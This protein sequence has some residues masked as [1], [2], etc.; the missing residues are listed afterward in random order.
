MGHRTLVSLTLKL[1][2]PHV[3]LVGSQVTKGLVDVVVVAGATAFVAVTRT[4]PPKRFSATA[5][6]ATGMSTA[7]GARSTP[8][9][10]VQ[11]G[12]ALCHRRTG[13]THAAMPTT[14]NTPPTMAST[15]K[16]RRKPVWKVVP[17]PNLNVSVCWKATVKPTE[18][19]TRAP[20]ISATPTMTRIRSAT[21]GRGAGA[22]GPAGDESRPLTERALCRLRLEGGPK[23]GPHRLVYPRVVEQVEVV[24][25]AEV[26]VIVDGQS[27]AGAARVHQ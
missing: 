26:T 12:K 14:T 9:T 2:T 20:S 15:M 16:L 27:A 18:A 25:P 23:P 17:G 1:G 19:K 11:R 3:V 10:P 6:T 24:Q 22:A 5:L 8:R 13:G 21:D 4:W 7:T